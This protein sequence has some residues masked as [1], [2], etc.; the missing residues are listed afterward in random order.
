MLYKC[1]YGAS[2]EYIE[3]STK[4]ECEDIFVAKLVFKVDVLHLDDVKIS[5]V[6]KT[7]TN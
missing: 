1:E 7:T 5:I 2:I 6:E 3:A 4:E